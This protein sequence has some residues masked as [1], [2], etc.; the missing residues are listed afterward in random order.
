MH[1]PDSA[2]R[3]YTLLKPI[4]T[5]L[6]EAFVDANL[7]K[8][9]WPYVSKHRVFTD[10]QLV[11]YKKYIVWEIAITTHHLSPKG[12]ELAMTKLNSSALLSSARP[13]TTVSG[14]RIALHQI[15]REIL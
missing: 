15:L 14:S 10:S 4:R 8:I 9:D 3:F 13:S 5:Y 12:V 6:C 11:K 1:N 7:A 2:P